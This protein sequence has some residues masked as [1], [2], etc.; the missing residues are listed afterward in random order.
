MTTL[1]YEEVLELQCALQSYWA[2]PGNPNPNRD[3]LQGPDQIA[4]ADTLTRKLDDLKLLAKAE[5]IAQK[6]EHPYPEDEKQRVAFF[7]VLSKAYE[8][9]RARAEYL[10]DLLEPTLRAFGF[11]T[12]FQDA[13]GTVYQ[14]ETPQGT[15]V[16]FRWI[17]WGRT[18]RP[19]EAKGTLSLEAAKKAGYIL[20]AAIDS[21]AKKR[22]QPEEARAEQ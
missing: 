20:P 4:F 10:Y 2:D 13:E 16:R 9:T 1:T 5:A 8:G 14:V 17:S 22:P 12:M 19:G 15:F 21:V 18:R 7:A 11:G 3:K 6:K